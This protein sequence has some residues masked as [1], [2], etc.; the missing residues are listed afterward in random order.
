MKSCVGQKTKA[1]HSDGIAAMAA[2]NGVN[3]HTAAD[4]LRQAVA[5]K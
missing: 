3:P 4:L 1:G 5:Q 2:Y